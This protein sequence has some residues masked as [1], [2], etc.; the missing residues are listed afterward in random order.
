MLPPGEKMVAMFQHPE[1]VESV[2][3]VDDLD[4]SHATSSS[5]GMS[6]T[7]DGVTLVT[8]SGVFKCRPKMS[9]E[10]LFL[11]LAVNSADTSA[12]DVLAITTGLDVNK[13]YEVCASLCSCNSALEYLQI[14]FKRHHLVARVGYCYQVSAVTVSVNV[15]S[16]V[17]H[18][19]PL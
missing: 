2:I 13:L 17:G 8:T 11:E 12:A 6:H 18:G 3:V 19:K 9:P 10:K 15:V 5:S 14:D 16:L 1:L 4:H 7:V